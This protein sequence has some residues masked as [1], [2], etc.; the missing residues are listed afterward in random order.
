ME[1]R[2]SRLSQP[3]AP[4]QREP[5]RQ[6]PGG[7]RSREKRLP[8]SRL[9]LLVDRLGW[10]SN[11]FDGRAQHR[12]GN[13]FDELQDRA[14][15]DHGERDLQDHCREIDFS[16]RHLAEPPVESG[17][18]PSSRASNDWQTLGAIQFESEERVTKILEI[19]A[20]PMKD[21]DARRQRVDLDPNDFW[22]FDQLSA[23]VRE[24]PH[25]VPLTRDLES[26][27]ASAAMGHIGMLSLM[28]LGGRPAS[29][30]HGAN[31]KPDR[32]F[33][34]SYRRSTKDR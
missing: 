3:W 27:T 2:S 23:Q 15:S 10:A 6:E 1:T 28:H 31:R 20:F 34:L 5:G 9:E 11:G 22:I 17:D 29:P 14:P 12:S 18:G 25:I 16:A 32:P 24:V 21:E 19:E 33:L 8:W 30:A 26:K 7:S 4:S 13:P